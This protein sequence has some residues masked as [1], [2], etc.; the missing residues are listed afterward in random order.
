[1][2]LVWPG[3][4]PRTWTGLLKGHI[5]LEPAGKNGF[6]YDPLFVPLGHSVT[7]AE[8]RLDQ[9]NQIS[10]RSRALAQVGTYLMKELA[11]QSSN[12]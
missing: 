5:A 4:T 7:L 2:A 12:R 9:K 8:M 3:K 11:K 6:G 1:M 10:H